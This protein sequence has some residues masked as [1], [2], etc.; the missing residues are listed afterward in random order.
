MLLGK[1]NPAQSLGRS[2]PNTLVHSFPFPMPAFASLPFAPAGMRLYR[3][4]FFTTFSLRCM[5]NTT[6]QNGLVV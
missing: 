3:D 1:T 2:E 6:S 4:Q 5:S